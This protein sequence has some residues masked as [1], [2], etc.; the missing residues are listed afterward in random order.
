MSRMLVRTFISPDDEQKAWL[1]RHA[2]LH[3]VSMA[4]LT[5]Q[6]VSEFR[7]RG[8]RGSTGPFQEVLRQTAGI[9]Q[10]GDGLEYQEPIR[11]EWP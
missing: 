6:A 3:R 9:W 4:S 5:R 10:P 2:A 1:D 7:M 11:K 8:Q